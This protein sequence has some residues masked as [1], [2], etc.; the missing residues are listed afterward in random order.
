[1]GEEGGAGCRLPQSRASVAPSLKEV[2]LRHSGGRRDVGDGPVPSLSPRLAGDS[3]LYEVPMGRCGASPAEL[4][5]RRPQGSPARGHM[6][7]H[8][9]AISLPPSSHGHPGH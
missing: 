4:K 3:P 8:S 9:S 7:P 5:G 6:G 2:W 1:M